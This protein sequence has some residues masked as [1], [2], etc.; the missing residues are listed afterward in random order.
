MSLVVQKFGGSSVATA[1]R[2]RAAARRALRAKQAGNQVIVV[3][4]ARG[5]TTD[6]LISLAREITDQPPAREMD[7]LLSTGE[8]ISIALMAMAIQALGQPAI[9]FTGAQIGI[10]TDSFH[11]KARIK[12]ISTQRMRQ[13]LEAGQIVIVAGF[14]GI[15]DEYNITTLGRGGSDT[16][17]VALAA[18]M[19]H[20]PANN[21]GQVGCEIYTDVDGVYTTDPRIVP[22][23]RKIDTISYDEMLELASVGAGVMHSR[24]IEFAKKFDVPLQ[25]RSSFSDAEG[26]W[27]VPET[28]WMRDVPVCGAAI[29][30][31]EARVNLDGVPDQPGVSHRVFSAIADQNIVVDMIAQ[32]VSTAGRTAI[33]FTVL[34]NELLA[35][36]RPVAVELGARV[37]HDEGVS[38]V[39]VVGTGMRTH[40]GVAE[41][42]F[43][44]LAAANINLKMITTGDIKISVLVDKAEGVKALRAVHQAF[45]LQE[46]RPG[47]G[48][49]GPAGPSPFRRRPAPIVE[50]PS[51]RDVATWT[52]RLSSMEE[53]IISDVLLNMDNGRIT[54]FDLPDRVGNCSRVFQAVAAGG[55]NVDMIVQNLT[56]AGHAELSFSVPRADLPRALELTQA[57]LPELDPATRV[58]ADANIAKLFVLGV[59]MRT[60]TGVAK[61][62]FGAL[63]SRGIN[64]SMINTS[65][66][67]VSA[68]VDRQ[69]GEEALACLKEAFNV[70]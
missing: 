21:N 15:D 44:A 67:C 16:T 36:L 4:S 6:E 51:G 62:M 14:Q 57:V 68:V 35:V 28:E 48:R 66:V 37:H 52:Q 38:K 23:A 55:I 45:N 12:N 70:H 2:I 5:D 58:V 30:R 43:A 41:R 50:E 24:S 1:E 63:A 64:I 20:D 11:T 46:P 17:A 10:T 49:A 9:S 22:E 26:T 69:R 42:M 7:M 54:I 18:V 53:I 19:K 3:V 40:T 27:I 8:Q 65:E 34:R 31:D 61:R 25:V 39:S 56:S 13:A 32:N 33:G 47:A 59:G 29:V 60:H